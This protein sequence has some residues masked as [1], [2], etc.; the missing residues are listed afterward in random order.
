MRS[1]KLAIL[2]LALLL[3]LCTPALA[4]SSPA[5]AQYVGEA[6]GTFADNTG[7]GTDAVNDALAGSASSTTASA[8]STGGG[9]DAEDTDH[10]GDLDSITELPE[11]GGI[12][13]ALAGVALLLVAVSI[14]RRMTS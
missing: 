9:D 1:F 14:T 7:Q 6:P 10:N 2:S 4:Q 5:D 11:T 13:P 12:P 3:A 8:T